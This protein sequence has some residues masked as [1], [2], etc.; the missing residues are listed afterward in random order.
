MVL[1]S[2]QAGTF[3]NIVRRNADFARQSSTVLFCNLA[4]TRACCCRRQPRYVASHARVIDT[5]NDNEKSPEMARTYRQSANFSSRL[6]FDVVSLLLVL[7]A[8]L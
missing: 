1:L 6:T 2:I 7:D 4:G 5:P 8:S 3:D